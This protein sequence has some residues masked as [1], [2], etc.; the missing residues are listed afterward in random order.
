MK[1]KIFNLLIAVAIVLSGISFA[2]ALPDFVSAL[3]Y[4]TSGVV[5]AG[6]A[7]V[8]SVVFTDINWT[9][10]DRIQLISGVASGTNWTELTLAGANQGSV[11]ATFNPA[12]Y[13]PSG[14]YLQAN[15]QNVNWEADI[16]FT[17]TI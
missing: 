8:T 7:Y 1:R 6:A 16:Q 10:Q 4:K 15:T 3:E 5:S 2:Y 13:F 17:N 14:I 11:Q 12:L 9:S